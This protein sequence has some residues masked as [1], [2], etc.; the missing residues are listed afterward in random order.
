[1]LA[2]KEPMKEHE[3]LLL[4]ITVCT[5]HFSSDRRSKKCNNTLKRIRQCHRLVPAGYLRED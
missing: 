5:F 2:E 1:M 4:P 3:T